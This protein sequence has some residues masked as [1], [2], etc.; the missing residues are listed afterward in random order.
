MLDLIL[1]Y[2]EKDGKIAL[3]GAIGNYENYSSRGI[4]NTQLI[5]SKRLTLTGLT[6]MGM[7]PNIEE[8]FEDFKGVNL[9]I[10][11]IKI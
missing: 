2:I 11:S 8:A 10:H 4:K 9:K 7:L 1:E 3:C 5:I 6:F